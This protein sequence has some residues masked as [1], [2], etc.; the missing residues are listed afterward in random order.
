M[1]QR[2]SMQRQGSL[3][4]AAVNDERVRALEEKIHAKVRAGGLRLTL[5]RRAICS[6]LARHGERFVT[7][8]EILAGVAENSPG[9]IDPSTGYRTLDEFARIGLVHHVNLGNQPGR[10]HLTLEHDHLHMVCETCERMT[11]VPVTEMQGTF[12]LLRDRHKFHV[13]LHHFAILGQCNDCR[14]SVGHGH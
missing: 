6:E 10:W 13:N 9:P 1:Q 7:A 14:E 5:P 8:Q 4:F 3:T 11:L 12:D 2:S